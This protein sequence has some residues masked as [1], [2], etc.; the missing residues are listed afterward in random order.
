MASKI[1]DR[2][3][4][5]AALCFSKRGFHGTSTRDISAHSN[6]TEGSLFRLFG[7]KDALFAEALD[8]VVSRFRARR[9]ISAA[10]ERFLAFAILD[11]PERVRAAL[12]R[13]R[14]PIKGA[15]SLVL[16]F[17]DPPALPKRKK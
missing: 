1:R 4:D 10:S 9:R 17:G 6:V 16:N 5:C 7:T 11:D 13:R 8:L 12:A 14:I 3:I 15:P 2:I